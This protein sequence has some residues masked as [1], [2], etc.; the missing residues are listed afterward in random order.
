MKVIEYLDKMHAK[1]QVSHHIPAFTAQEMAAYEHVPGLHVAKTVIIN[2]DGQYAMCV[3]PACFMVD[4]QILTDQL[5]AKEVRLADESEMEKLFPDCPVGAE[6][7]FGN[8]YE[9]ATY[10][11]RRLADTDYIVFQG[12]SHEEAVRMDMAEYHKLVHP[13]VLHFSHPAN[14]EDIDRLRSNPF[15]D[16]YFF[17]D[18]FYPL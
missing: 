5:G 18:P 17:F 1:F 4:M 7:P 8:L 12:G 16:D 15:Y 14:V 6:P 9:L 3:L 13:N 11:D 10:L 2:V